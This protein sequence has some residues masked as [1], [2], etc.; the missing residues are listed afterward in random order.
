MNLWA[1]G[2]SA[3]LAARQTLQAKIRGWILA[4]RPVSSP[5]TRPKLSCYSNNLGPTG[6]TR[7]F[8]FFPLRLSGTSDDVGKVALNLAATKED[9]L[10][11]KQQPDQLHRS[12]VLVGEVAGDSGQKKLHDVPSPFDLLDELKFPLQNSQDLMRAG[13]LRRVKIRDLLG[14]GES[15]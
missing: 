7:F 12:R 11:L 13:G 14:R 8:R 10:D 6:P 5:Q 4:A 9:S 2:M 1:R 15:D 3:I